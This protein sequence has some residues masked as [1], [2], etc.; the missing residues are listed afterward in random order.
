M[1]KLTILSL[2]LSMLTIMSILAGCVTYIEGEVS[3]QMADTPTQSEVFPLMGDALWCQFAGT[4]ATITIDQKRANFT[5]EAEGDAETVLL[6]E[7]TLGDEGWMIEKA[8]LTHENEI[9]VADSTVQVIVDYIEL[10]DGTQCAFAG[11]GATI[12]VEQERVNYTCG[13]ENEADVVL[14][15]DVQIGDEG[16]TILKALIVPTDDG[17][18][19]TES[20][21]MLITA[22]GVN[23]QTLAEAETDI[24]DELLGT[25]QWQTFEDSASGAE[26]NDISVDNPE[27]YT[28]TITEDGVA[29]IMADCNNSL[30]QLTVDGSRL[31]FAAGPMTLAACGPDSLDTDFVSLL[32]DVV[33][34]VMNDEGNLVLNLKIDAGNMIFARGE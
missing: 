29:Q 22:L 18:T 24:P 33:T 21:M 23:E 27:K 15:G 1:K 17:F 26:S 14:A 31:T 20:K 2:L 34:Y 9:F 12:A 6:G 10:E 5:C 25:W 28:L 3:D 8:N 11:T 4:G 13:T 16:W 30:S 19:T 32:L 7:I